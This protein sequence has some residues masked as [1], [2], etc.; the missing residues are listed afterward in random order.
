MA[1]DGA[2]ARERLVGARYPDQLHPAR[3]HRPGRSNLEPLAQPHVDLSF[4]RSPQRLVISIDYLCLLH[5]YLLLVASLST[6]IAVSLARAPSDPP[7]GTTIGNRDQLLQTSGGNLDQFAAQ[8]SD[9]LPVVWRQR[10]SRRL[11]HDLDCARRILLPLE[12]Q[13]S[14]VARLHLSTT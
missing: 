3:N 1:G 6:R 2:A 10:P 12:H 14:R 11:L 5:L 7:F 8:Q 9:C 4:Q 13:N